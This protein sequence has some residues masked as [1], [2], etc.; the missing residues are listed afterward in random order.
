MLG[1]ELTCYHGNPRE[2]VLDGNRVGVAY[3][4]VGYI[5]IDSERI[6]KISNWI[7]MLFK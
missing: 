6:L 3:R 2:S 4:I 1:G 7:Q 5:E